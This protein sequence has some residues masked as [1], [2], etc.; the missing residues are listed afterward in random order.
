MICKWPTNFHCILRIRVVCQSNLTSI[1]FSSPSNGTNG[2]YTI[3]KPFT[4][5]CLLCTRY[6]C[7]IIMNM[8]ICVTLYSHCV[9][10][11]QIIDVSFPTETNE[12]GSSKII[13]HSTGWRP[14]VL[15]HCHTS[16]ENVVHNKYGV[17]YCVTE[18]QA[19]TT[20]VRHSWQ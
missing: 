6:R 16:T 18:R 19:P 1:S 5:L 4:L 11:Y 20:W 14:N 8:Y 7:Q 2:Y 10:Q 13:I 12:N 17:V 3:Y 9:R 15:C